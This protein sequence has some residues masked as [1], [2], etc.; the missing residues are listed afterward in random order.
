MK[1]WKEYCDLVNKLKEEMER[2]SKLEELVNECELMLSKLKTEVER[3][4]A[5]EEELKSLDDIIIGENPLYY[6]LIEDIFSKTKM[7]RTLCEIREEMEANETWEMLAD[8][9]SVKDGIL[10]YR[11]EKGNI[12]V[13]LNIA[14]DAS[15]CMVE[16][17]NL[18]LKKKDITYF[19]YVV[20]DNRKGTAK[21]IYSIFYCK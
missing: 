11:I 13:E 2:N 1:Q 17:P 7:Q 15:F 6:S 20:F 10:T 21:R 9:I 4:E 19:E 12:I 3:I 18:L 5:F 8:F 14:A 16:S